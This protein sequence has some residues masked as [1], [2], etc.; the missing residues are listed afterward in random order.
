MS[1]ERRPCDLVMKGGVTSGIVYPS[2]IYEISRAFD[3]KSIGGTSA[4]AIAAALAAAAQYRRL[5]R[6]GTEDAE[7]GYE[8]LRRCP[9]GSGAGGHLF[10]LFAP[11]RLT[12]RLFNSLPASRCRDRSLAARLAE[13]SARVCPRG[14]AR[15]AAGRLRYSCGDAT[16]SAR[17]GDRARARFD[18]RRAGRR[19][20]PPRRPPSRSKRCAC[21]RATATV[22]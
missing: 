12:R 16:R 4:G 15:R 22:W 21:C 14:R 9:T 18:R 10:G 17:R 5:R 19:A 13:A 1:A 11:N 6:A 20:L 2:A 8:R 3:L 7:A